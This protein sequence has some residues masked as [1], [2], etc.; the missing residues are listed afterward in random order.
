M[1]TS[2]GPIVLDRADGSLATLAIDGQ[3]ARAVAL[4]RRDTAELIAEELRRLDPDDTYA[5]ALRYGV[6]RLDTV[7][8]QSAAEPAGSGGEAVAEP[9]PVEEAAKAPAKKAAAKT[10]KKAPAR[11]AAAK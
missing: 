11:K 4:K 10:A 1:T 8:E 7:P 3:P 9:E 2:G 5:S 6:E